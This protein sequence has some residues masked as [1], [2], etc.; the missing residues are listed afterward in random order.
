MTR[1][2][3][4]LLL[5]VAVTFAVCPP[6]TAASAFEQH[7]RFLTQ[8]QHR[9]AGS[10]ADQRVGDYIVGVLRGLGFD[11]ASLVVQPVE[12]V[13]PAN[14]PDDCF[15]EAGGQ[16]VRIYPLR[17]NLV[18]AAV[19]GPEG[20][21][22]SALYCRKGF[23]DSLPSE[24]KGRIVLLDY[25][26]GEQW[27]RA[28][29]RGAKAVVFVGVVE[30]L[31]AY[32]PKFYE[33]AADLPRFYLNVED[34]KAMG[35]LDRPLDVRIQA[36]A[37]W[38]RLLT[39]NIVAMVHPTEDNQGDDSAVI[40]GCEYDSYGDVPELAPTYRKAL[41]T[42]ALLDLAETLKNTPSS[43]K[44]LLCFFG[45]GAANHNGARRFY[46]SI[47][48][49]R[50]RKSGYDSVLDA[51]IEYLT[52]ERTRLE[53]TV[54]FLL[55]ERERLERGTAFADEGEGILSDDFEHHAELRK[56][57]KSELGYKVADIR[58]DAI[59]L[60]QDIRRNVYPE[61]LVPEKKEELARLNETIRSWNNLN[62]DIKNRVLTEKC[63]P[64]Y[65][66]VR[67]KALGVMR[68][69]LR[70]L[71]YCLEHL[72]AGERIGAYLLNGD[73]E[74]TIISHI[75]LNLSEQGD[76]WG[77][78][79]SGM[80]GPYKTILKGIQ[81][82]TRTAEMAWPVAGDQGLGFDGLTP[83]ALT[84]VGQ[85][86]PG[87]AHAVTVIPAGSGGGRSGG[88]TVSDSA[89][90]GGEG[91]ELAVRNAAVR[92][93]FAE[94]WPGVRLQLTRGRGAV[95]I[96]VNGETRETDELSALDG[97]TVG[98]AALLTELAADGAGGMLFVKGEVKELVVG[99]AE[100]WLDAVHPWDPL[101]MLQRATFE[102]AIK[103]TA[104]F[105]VQPSLCADLSVS[106][107]AFAFSFSTLNTIDPLY[108]TPFERLDV[109]NMPRFTRQLEEV[110][111]LLT[112]LVREE[113]FSAQQPT[114]D[115]RRIMDVTLTVTGD[116]SGPL[117]RLQQFGTA[118][119][120]YPCRGAIAALDT[121]SLSLL[122]PQ[123][124]HPEVNNAILVRSDQL[125][126]MA[127]GP[128]R[129]WRTRKTI[130][131]PGPN[132][133]VLSMNDISQPTGDS[134]VVFQGNGGHIFNVFNFHNQNFKSY[135]APG[136][137]KLMKSVGNV[138]FRRY[139]TSLTR[140]VLSFFV[141]GKDNTQ[142]Y[143]VN[144]FMLLNLSEEGLAEK[145]YGEGFAIKDRSWAAVD[146]E[147]RS[148]MDLHLLNESRLKVLRRKN[149]VNESLEVLHGKT[150]ELLKGGKRLAAMIC[151]WRVYSPLKGSIDDIVKAAVILLLMIVP[152]AFVLER[153][154]VGAT[155]VY[156]QIAG[157][158]VFFALTFA[159]L[160]AV[161]P[162]F[163]IAGTPIIIFLAFVIII[164]SGYVIF[165]I[166]QRFKGEIMR[167]Q[168]LETS[169]H[170]A[171][172]SRFN[173]LIAAVSLGISTMRRRPLRTV[174]TSVTIILLTFT[175]LC[176]SSF[177]TEI[178]VIM[179]YK[180]QLCSDRSILVHTKDWS[181]L[182]PRN[183]QLIESLGEGKMKVF[184]RYWLSSS[185]ADV[186]QNRE[187]LKVIVSDV[188]MRK[189]T[190]LDA[191]MGLDPDEIPLKRGL[192]ECLDGD[193]ELLRS[194]GVFL[195]PMTIE[196]LGL[197][198]GDTV[199]VR[200][201]R[202]VLAGAVNVDKMAGMVHLDGSPF[203]PVDYSSIKNI[204]TSQDDIGT[205]IESMD[206]TQFT[207][208][209]PEMVALT[210]NRMVALL[211]G[212]L[213]SVVA[214]AT[215][216]VDLQPLVEEVALVF[217]D[218]V[219]V[220]LKDGV[221]AAYFTD[222]LSFSGLGDIVAPLLLGGLI[223]FT[224]M[225]ASVVDR[226]REIYAFSALGLAPPHVASLFFAEASVYAI[227]GGLGGY[228][229]SQVV[230]K[231]LALLSR[232]GWVRVPELNPSSLTAIVTILIVM[233]V[234]LISTIYPAIKASKSAN[235]GI[236]RAWRMPAAQGDLLDV[237]FPFTVSEYDLTGIVSFLKEHFVNFGDST[238]GTFSSKEA[239]VFLD[240]EQQA[241]ALR[242]D[243]WLAPF[244]L[245]ISQKFTLTSAPSGIEGIAEVRI[246][247]ERLSGSPGSWYRSNK[248][249]LED[250]RRQ[251]LIW[252]T[253]SHDHAEMYRNRSLEELGAAE[254]AAEAGGSDDEPSDDQG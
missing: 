25:D 100:V 50:E 92:F 28:F 181:A 90:A 165:V 250:L 238:L 124:Y 88:V 143:H 179:S 166:M 205:V 254:G 129:R 82:A 3:C 206:S 108:G 55:E 246:H 152:F 84:P 119:A 7:V 5:T 140:D 234:T 117:V 216:A 248:M 32:E 144:S 188:E 133:G 228:L 236:Q 66:Y 118:L 183:V 10:E 163:D 223:I 132:G 24:L 231:F 184:G 247:I 207:S 36:K 145:R 209:P 182:H 110:R 241:P 112:R 136:H 161:H 158:G 16:R 211:D 224:T 51:K 226:E 151:E 85:P 12:V 229:F 164:A 168:G 104:F 18:Q 141:W 134:H 58:E 137:V 78:T 194:N 72:G 174:L 37:S 91:N 200:G 237:T 60:S 79:I 252:R 212:D 4:Q 243:I 210:S 76:R 178:G 240:Q 201:R 22:G 83:G 46:Y 61:E 27:K 95:S 96:G 57:L 49:K 162:A 215:E 177:N 81:G 113:N 251:F 71:E 21:S 147:E 173:T 227:I 202:C 93:V 242:S 195:A 17:P 62:R 123:V 232:F 114:P 97:D 180:G 105:P 170:Q 40:V 128:L 38:D 208:V 75:S 159:V 68:E 189:H 59:F 30:R 146:V 103:P 221:Y 111:G 87:G 80:L 41:N 230:V 39:A 77:L 125:G 222:E 135:F 26:C 67:D 11:D 171:D 196:K 235:P 154:L 197:R 44:V 45:D 139:H 115:N 121:Y 9:L 126:Y 63:R 213:R 48:Q 122:V 185:L 6:A 149:I 107:G 233:A 52:D 175:I 31:E 35:L 160:Y 69:R 191:V 217:G 54:R 74:T 53:E 193:V 203:M 20:L 1:R 116:Y 14:G 131:S 153:L 2:V 214:Y 157:F 218:F 169:L 89:R 94:S 253:V 204:M 86:L 192:R 225:L 99:G 70:E 155:I 98:G 167:I 102:G 101:P 127:Y 220:G 42:A 244:D 106:V 190:A 43:R 65:T 130:M 249:F 34:A 148:A 8:F 156:K 73:E 15:L 56:I 186:V 13:R 33:A 172:V 245:G 239:R 150:A 109:A 176:F 47:I 199:Y 64:H 142:L 19:T 23:G 138:A 29:E 219:Y 120:D 198:A 187:P